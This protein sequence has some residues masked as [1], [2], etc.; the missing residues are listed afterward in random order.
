MSKIEST[1]LGRGIIKLFLFF[2]AVVMVVLV[3]SQHHL[4][5]FLI[6]PEERISS[7]F[8]CWTTS[9]FF[10]RLIQYH[11]NNFSWLL[12]SISFALKVCWMHRSVKMYCSSW[13]QWTWWTG[14]LIK[15]FIIAVILIKHHRLVLKL[16]I[17]SFPRK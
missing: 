17:P 15:L 10:W 14:T 11:L 2:L 12:T 13:S 6:A 8:N 7:V 1:K 4:C 3:P 9:F 16:I 5:T